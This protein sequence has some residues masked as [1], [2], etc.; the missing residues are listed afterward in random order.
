VFLAGLSL[1]IIWQV[2][3]EQAVFIPLHQRLGLLEA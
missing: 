3:D 2:L 1:S